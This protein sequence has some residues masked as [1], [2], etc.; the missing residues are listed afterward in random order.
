[1]GFM[2]LTNTVVY[3]ALILCTLSQTVFGS[4]TFRSEDRVLIHTLGDSF[5]KGTQLEGYNSPAMLEQHHALLLKRHT[6][7][8]NQINTTS[9]I[10]QRTQLERQ[11][12]AL[13]KLLDKFPA[14][15]E[16]TRLLYVGGT[17]A[18]LQH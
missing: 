17:A 1:M 13:E 11:K 7:L 4:E 16:L 6:E 15:L 2:R 14:A 8:I 3:Y 18:P 10:Q 12:S 5:A 9:D